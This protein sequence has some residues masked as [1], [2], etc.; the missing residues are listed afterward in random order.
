MR[1]PFVEQ[2]LSSLII[3][4]TISD[5]P[6]IQAQVATPIDYLARTFSCY[7]GGGGTPLNGIPW[8]SSCCPQNGRG[9]WLAQLGSSYIGV[10]SENPWEFPTVNAPY[11]NYGSGWAGF[12]YRKVPPNNVEMRGLI[13]PGAGTFPG[14]FHTLPSGV[15]DTWRPSENWVFITHTSAAY[16]ELRINSD[17]TCVITGTVGAGGW[18]SVNCNFPLSYFI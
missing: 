17:G 12:G 16:S 6:L 1:Q 18:A 9:I 15:G 5:K 7:L 2:D 13:T 11:G 8:L 14:T 3:A 10:L 4:K